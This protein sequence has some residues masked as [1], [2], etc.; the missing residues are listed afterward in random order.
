METKSLHTHVDIVSRS[1]GHSVLAKAAY[2]A[3]D[4]LKDD[5]YGK[6]HDYSKKDDLVFSKIFLPEHIPKEFSNREYLWNSVEKIE[7]SKNSQLA[8]NLLFTLPRE[9][10]EEDRIKL[11]SEFIE[12]NFT[13]KGMIADCNIHNPIAS[14]NE[15]QP[16]AHILLTLREIDEQGN[17]KAKS[18]KEYILDEN[19]EK[20][21]LK[22]GNYKSRKVNLND[23]NEPDKAKEWRENFSKKANEYLAKNNIDKRIDPR[24]FEEQGREELPQVHL[25]T[26]SYQMEKKG[27]QTERGNHN[28][29]IIA[30]NLEFKKLKA[31]LSKLTSWISSLLGNL[32]AKYDEYKQTRQDEIDN[33]AELFNLYEYISIYY[34]LQGEKARKLNPY[35]SN[36]KIGAD[37][38]RFSKARIYL[39]DN[40]LKTIADLQEKISTLQAKNKNINQDIKAKTKRIENLNKCFAYADIIKDN[41]QVF[42]EWSSKSL[43]KDSFYNSH[44]EQIDKYKRAR[45][46]IE[47]ITGSSAIKSKD[48]QKE[49]ESL[50]DEITKLSNKSQSIKEEYESINH[51]KYAVKTVND[52]YG[53]D[54][55]IEIDKAIKRGEKPSVIAQLRKYQEQGAKYEQRKEKAKDYYRNEER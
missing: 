41:K 3:R 55:S 23:W 54:L 36:K 34:D 27:I 18:K 12:G 21:K 26:A 49:I 31:E 28:R 33:K 35:A 22:R 17:W 1:K 32:Q 42:E 6:T 24:T 43:F 46:I 45:A 14:D 16:H 15:E 8:R 20:I 47:K 40:N 37:L 7:K 11:I 4:K 10:N 51:I 30:F 2:N 13:S 5:Y 53:I 48:W 9:L 38:R 50:E 25:G 52:D 44:K 39:K 19:G 29:K